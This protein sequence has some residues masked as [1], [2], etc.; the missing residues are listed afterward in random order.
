MPT[1]ARVIDPTALD[2]DAGARA[3]LRI[4]VPAAWLA[5]G[6]EL[7]IVC[8]ARLACARC[9]GGGCDGCGRSGALRAPVEAE[10]R[11]LRARM[12]AGAEGL[13][14]RLPAPFGPGHPVDQLVLEIRPAED[15]SAG[16]RRIPR[17]AAARIRWPAVAA[18]VAALAAVAA[19]LLAR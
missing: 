19:A 13:A 17:P 11:T 16:V 4:D 8:P 12:P 6:A 14:I 5:G 7:E 9:D 15:P 10:A 18:V 1:L 3:R 2:D